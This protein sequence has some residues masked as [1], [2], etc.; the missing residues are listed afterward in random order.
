MKELEEATKMKAGLL[1][2]ILVRRYGRPKISVD[3]ALVQQSWNVDEVDGSSILYMGMK[4]EGR[5]GA[6]FTSLRKIYGNAYGGFLV[7]NSLKIAVLMPRKIWGLW[8]IDELEMLPPVRKVSTIDPAI[9][10]F[11]DSANVW[12]YGHK[13]GEL[14][15]F[16]TET[17]E[18][19]CLGAIEPAIETLMDQWEEAGRP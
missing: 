14:Y 15:V 12:Y 1:E 2:K 11:M 10:F 4:W 19:D 18:L 9:D 5:L 13:A 3:G 17:D 7:G 6:R 16:D 8:R